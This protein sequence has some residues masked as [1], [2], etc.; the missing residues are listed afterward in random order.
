RAAR[1]HPAPFRSR[2]RAPAL[3]Q[4]R[5]GRSRRACRRRSGRAHPLPRRPRRILGSLPAHQKGQ[6]GAPDRRAI[7]PEQTMTQATALSE[8]VEKTKGLPPIRRNASGRIE[9][10]P[11]SAESL[12]Q[13]TVK[14]LVGA[15]REDLV[16][17]ALFV[18]T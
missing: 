13:G 18:E 9:G 16:E 4:S 2:E 6:D 7:A 14:T 3:Q 10:W 12:L 5:K 15:S 1:R 17:A 11:D 8:L